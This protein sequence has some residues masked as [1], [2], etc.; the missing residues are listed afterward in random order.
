MGNKKGPQDPE[1]TRQRLLEAATAEFSKNG[2]QGGRIVTIA[3]QAGANVQSIYYH[4]GSKE[5]LYVATLDAR[6]S[7]ASFEAVIGAMQAAEPTKGL[8]RLIDF[9]FDTYSRKDG[10]LALLIEQDMQGAEQLKQLPRV[11]ALFARLIAALQGVLDRGAAQG[12][13]H[14]RQDATRVYLSITGLAGSYLH[15]THTHTALL[16][17][18]FNAPKE[19]AAWRKHVEATVLASVGAPPPAPRPRA[20]T[21]RPPA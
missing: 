14:P 18:D 8:S 3:Q 20:R 10:A 15:K 2:L 7:T 4:F 21:I 19:L 17:R 12:L 5:Q 6:Y 11:Q 13:F 9:M 1:R 16:G